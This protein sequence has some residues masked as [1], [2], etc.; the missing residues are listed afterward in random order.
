MPSPEFSSNPLTP[1]FSIPFSAYVGLGKNQG[2]LY[3]YEWYSSGDWVCRLEVKRWKNGKLSRKTFAKTIT[4][5]P[6][7]A[8]EDVYSLSPGTVDRLQKY[9]QGK[10]GI[11]LR[12]VDS[13]EVDHDHKTGA[14]RGLLCHR[15]NVGL[16]YF[17]EDWLSSARHYIENPP[18]NLAKSSKG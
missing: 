3:Y 17:E 18:A 15:C 6:S 16:G 12:Y 11:C 10:C 9:Q 7:A 5:S 14:I 1:S 2:S 4:V 13:L 8:V